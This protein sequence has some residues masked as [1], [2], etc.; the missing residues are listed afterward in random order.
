MK[1]PIISLLC[2]SGLAIA[3]NVSPANARTR[4]KKQKEEPESS[5]TLRIPAKAF[6]NLKNSVSNVELFTSNH[7]IIGLDIAQSQGGGFWPR[8]SG[9]NY[10][11]GGGLW[12]G[13]KKVPRNSGSSDTVR[14]CVVSY[15]PNSGTSW[16]APGPVSGTATQQPTDI[17]PQGI[18][19]NR[20]YNSHDYS[21]QTGAPIDPADLANGGPYWPIWDTKSHGTSRDQGYFG[22]YISDPSQ[23][24]AS[25]N[26]NGPAILS[27]EDIFCVYRDNDLKRYG[28]IDSATAAKAGFPLG[29]QVEQTLYSWGFGAYADIIFISYN[30]INKSSDTL[31]ECTIAPMMDF[32]VGKTANN[33]HAIDVI[34][35]LNEDSLLMAVQWSETEA[36]PLG[37]VGMKFLE[38]PAPDDRGFIR[39]DQAT[40]SQQERLG[41]SVFR[42]WTIDGDP[43]TPMQ[44]YDF[45]S[46]RSRRDMDLSVGDFRFMMGAGPFN[47]VPGDTARLVVALLFAMPNGKASGSFSSMKNII[48][49]G[50]FSQKVYNA[51]F[52]I[53]ASV[54]YSIP[55]EHRAAISIASIQPSIIARGGSASVK[56]S[57][58]KSSSAALAIVDIRGVEVYRASLGVQERGEHPATFETAGLPSGAYFCI[59]ETADGAARTKFM[60]GE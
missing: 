35:N 1:Y 32:D 38:C 24:N 37:Y 12:F 42:R 13:A 55:S 3:L 33:D 28:D 5:K 29:I 6:E 43:S 34:P 50:G 25:S 23:R 18:N 58:E 47:M 26:P 8:G 7:G 30:V 56:Y 57:L 4:P 49:L 60:V 39:H 44:R 31:I 20:L 59:I 51:N 45:I 40:Y 41:L 14:L 48:E 36:V 9:H 21:P 53:P 46:D 17:T 22:N 52:Q 15:E 10:I 11:F 16:M 19:R 54:E 2:A 27:G